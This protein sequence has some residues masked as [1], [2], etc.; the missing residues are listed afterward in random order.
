M[1]VSTLASGSVLLEALAVA[2]SIG[3]TAHVWHR[4]PAMLGSPG[5]LVLGWDGRLPQEWE[6]EPLPGGESW[7]GCRRSCLSSPPI[8]LPIS[9]RKQKES[10][11][12]AC[13]APS[14]VQLLTCSVCFMVLLRFVSL[15]SN[16]QNI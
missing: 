5:C 16:F 1:R 10:F 13:L 6:S 14:A 2:L 15:T 12:K 7:Q 11:L 3:P 8:S 9:V 4:L